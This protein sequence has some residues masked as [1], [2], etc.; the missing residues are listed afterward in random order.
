[1]EEFL[2]NH[3]VIVCGGSGGVGKTTISAALGVLAANHGLHV[4]VLT[5]DPAKRL[6]TALGL[7]RIGAND[8]QIKL[9]TSS[10]GKLHISMVESKVIFDQFVK[11]AAPNAGAAD[12]LLKNRL[13]EKLSTTLSGSQ[14]YTSLEKLYSSVNDKK[15]DLIIL[16]TPPSKHAL[17]F[18]KSP[19]KIYNL[20]QDSVLTWFMKKQSG[21]EVGFIRGLIQQGTMR[22]IR[23][24]E[25]LTG[26]GFVDEMVEFFNAVSSWQ[27]VLRDHSIAVHNLLTSDKTAFV[28]V[29]SFDKSKI[30][31]ARTFYK[32]LRKGGYH[33]HKVIINRS[34]PEWLLDAEELATEA[35][36]GAS[37]EVKSLAQYATAI[38]KFYYRH[39]NAYNNFESE[40]G[41]ESAR[42]VRVQFLRIRDFDEDIVDLTG[43]NRV[44]DEIQGVSKR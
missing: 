10:G 4:L 14:E 31:E 1:M 17:D 25:V 28:L 40:V 11:A 36:K 32:E 7:D 30:A 39:Q 19:Q 21:Q 44:A 23:T 5:I 15:Y 42:D 2:K 8:T 18:L 33:L 6:A 16:D 13:Y 34:L 24:L 3:K 12:K 43:L 20:F 29:T 26:A 37:D 41:Q 27:P 22:A 35:L 9:E 38:K